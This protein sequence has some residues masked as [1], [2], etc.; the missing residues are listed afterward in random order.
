LRPLSNRLPGRLSDL[1]F[2]LSSYQISKRWPVGELKQYADFRLQAGDVVLAMDRPWIE[3]GLKY[4]WINPR[5]PT[6][7]LVQRVARLRGRPTLDQT[8][9]RYIIGSPAFTN[10]IKPIVTG[11]NVPHISG[12]QIKDFQFRLPPLVV[13]QQAASIL[14]AYDDLIENNTRRIQILEQMAQAIYRE[15]FVNYRFPGHEKVKLVESPLGKIPH[16]WVVKHLFDIAEITY[17][18]PFKSKLFST[19]QDGIPVIRIRDI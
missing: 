7:L 9:L 11:V 15:W 2:D 5:D 12:Q 6:A 1:S 10:Y 14:S 3:A 19:H 16:G 8:F 18:F 17:G 13:Q 4:A